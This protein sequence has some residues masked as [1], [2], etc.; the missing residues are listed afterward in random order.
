MET[1]TLSSQEDN[2]YFLHNVPDNNNVC[3]LQIQDIE[4][5]LDQY[6]VIAV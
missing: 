1:L 3:A 6:S 2:K 5:T 4:P